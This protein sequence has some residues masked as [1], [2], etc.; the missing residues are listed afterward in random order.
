MEMIPASPAGDPMRSIEQ[1]WQF[2]ELELTV[3]SA[4]MARAD[5][6]IE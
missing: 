4:L 1:C 2:E 6:E 3:P 5:E